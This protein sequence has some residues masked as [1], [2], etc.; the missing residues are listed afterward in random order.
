[1][2]GDELRELFVAVLV[3]EGSTRSSRSTGPSSASASETSTSSS[4]RSS[5]RVATPRRAA[6]DILHHTWRTAARRSLPATLL[7]VHGAASSTARRVPRARDSVWRAATQAPA[8]HSRRRFGLARRRLDYDSPRRHAGRHVPRRRRLRR[9]ED[10]KRRP[11][12]PAT[13]SPTRSVPHAST[14]ALTS[15]STNAGAEP[16]CWPISATS[17]SS[18]SPNARCTTCATSFG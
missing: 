5:S 2:T 8:R 4:S 13:S 18:A 16:A 3:V 7:A 15:P 17:A 10:P 14:T 12:E 1:M 9:A 6:D 11:S